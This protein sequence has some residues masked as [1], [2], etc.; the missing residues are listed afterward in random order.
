[1]FMTYTELSEGFLVEAEPSYVH[2]HSDPEN[3][4]Y[5]FSYKIRITNQGSSKAQLVSRRW[6]IVDGKQ[7]KEEVEGPGVV[8]EQP[9]LDTG[10]TYEYTS[11]CPLTTPTGSMR[12][13]YIMT[14]AD[15]RIF[16]IKIPLF[17]LRDNSHNN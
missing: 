4:Q 13:N 1:M 12:G 6:I 9:R 17:F 11:F 7:N 8:G 3:G 16:S 15:G 5:F 14:D 10:A 2:E